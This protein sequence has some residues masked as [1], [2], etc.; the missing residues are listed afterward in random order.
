MNDVHE[1]RARSRW[2]LGWEPVDGMPAD[3]VEMGSAALSV[4]QCLPRTPSFEDG[5]DA[6]E[7]KRSGFLGRQAS[8][9]A[10]ESEVAVYH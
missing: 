10:D 4:G 7:S 5:V 1:H 8:K 2:I 3:T 9:G 6:W